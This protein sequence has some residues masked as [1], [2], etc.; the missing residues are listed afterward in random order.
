MAA[1]DIKELLIKV[2]AGVFS[3]NG[4]GHDTAEK[5]TMMARLPNL[6]KMGASGQKYVRQLR[7]YNEKF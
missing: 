4:L 7:N 1:K 6:E 2:A 5:M 3:V